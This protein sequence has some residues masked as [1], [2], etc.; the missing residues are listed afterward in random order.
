MMYDSSGKI[1]YVGKASNLRNRV[2]SY[3]SKSADFSPKIKQLVRKIHKFDYILTESDQEAVILECNLIKEHKPQYNARLKDDKSYPFI[4]IDL[5]QEFP[6]VTITRNPAN[7]GS[8]YFG[9]FASATSVRR[10]LGLLKKLFPYRSCTKTITGN[11]D[12]ACLD[13]YINRCIGPCIGAAD[14]TQYRTVINQVQLFMEGDTKE[15]VKSITR[16]MQTAADNLEFERAAAMRDQL[17]AIEKV[18]QSQKVVGLN[19]ESMDIIAIEVDANEAWVEIF[20]VRESKVVGREHFMMEGIGDDGPDKVLAA[21][22]KQFYE[23][24]P[25][26]PPNILVQHL[27][28]EDESISQW[29]VKKRGGQVQIRVP[30]R[31]EKHR[32]IQLA[33]RNATHGMEQLKLKKNSDKTLLNIAL[34]EIQESL[35]LANLPRTI[36]C[37]DISNIQGTNAVGSMVVFQNG[38]PLRKHYKRFKIKQV[39]GI[40]DY[41]MM[42]EVLKRRFSRL[43][44]TRDQI[45]PNP[46]AKTSKDKE[47]GIIP[48][49]VLID[50]G[51]GHLS[52]AQ[53]IFLELG[54]NSIPLASL[55][56]EEEL[57]FVPEIAEPIFLP[58]KS[59]GLFL[60]QRLRDEA[61]RF[62]ITF[63]RQ[64]RSKA[65]LKSPLDSVPGIGPK[66][67][68]LLIREFGSVKAIRQ[69]TLHEIESVSGITSKQAKSVSEYL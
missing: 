45:Q 38:V 34:S 47:W 29:L 46:S 49:L 53:Q 56:K 37:Y 59:Q 8:R 54:L 12:R 22:I 4:K 27:I 52:A 24:S 25:T 15:I 57:I 9:P 3:F 14:K 31:G 60:V 67:K 39:N 17:E 68:R 21:F 10:T 50:G 1:L 18:H 40:D 20:F 16:N 64:R 55:A 36:E 2:R 44:Q 65:S 63:H 41:S 11:D 51:K 32:L 58:R 30:K 62:A 13:F 48:D 26:V 42:R 61:H 43:A 33:S 69:A 23:S 28:E 5:S 66:S 6:Q 19:S 35:S 7:D